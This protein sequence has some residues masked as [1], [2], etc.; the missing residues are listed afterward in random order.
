[1]LEQRILRRG[2]GSL[3]R[4]N[5][6]GRLAEQE[7]VSAATWKIAALIEPARPY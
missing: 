6:P 3:T 7:R 4:G 5:S 1:M 2:D